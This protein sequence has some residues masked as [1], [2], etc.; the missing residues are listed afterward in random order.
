MRIFSYKLYGAYGKQVP[1]NEE[2][3]LDHFL[4]YHKVGWFHKEDYGKEKGYPVVEYQVCDFS[5]P[6]WAHT[7]DYKTAKVDAVEISYSKE[8]MSQKF[9]EQ[10]GFPL[11]NP[12]D[13]RFF[14][15]SDREGKWEMDTVNWNIWKREFGHEP[16]VSDKVKSLFLKED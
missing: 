1:V 9:Q 12:K 5:G 6:S 10:F 2:E 4:P 11:P 8:Y 16:K 13:Q 15:W 7:C 3:F 14:F